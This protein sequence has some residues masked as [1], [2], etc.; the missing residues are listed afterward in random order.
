MTLLGTGRAAPPARPLGP[1]ASPR[2]P[3]DGGPP[4]SRPRRRTWRRGALVLL[5]V[6]LLVPAVSYGRALA[7]PGGGDWQV[8]SVEWI[9]DHGGT[10][11]VNWVENW[12][13]AHH[14]P[15]GAAP[16][17]S[18]LPRPVAGAGTPPGIYEPPA[19]PT[20]AGHPA[21]PGEGVWVP[22][23]TDPQGRPADYTTFLRPDP[24]HPSVVVGAAWVRA[25]DT[26]AHLAAGLR[27]PG[28][29]G[30]PDAGRV[31][32]TDVPA[33]VATFNS[34]W[35][36]KDIHGGFY[37]DGRTGPTLVD[38]QA[39]AVVD[40][41]GHLTVGQWGR[42]VWM[43]PHVRA[44]RQNLALV[45]D[46]GRPVPGLTVD[47]RGRW[48]SSKNQLQYTWRSGLG[49]DARGNLIYVAGSGLRL[50]TLARAMVDAGIQ[51]G[52]ELDIHT[53]MASFSSWQPAAGG[54]VAPTKL[55]PTM[56]RPADRYLSPDQRDFFYV[57]LRPAL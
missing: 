15:T 12:W 55:L 1:G 34:G 13:Y 36:F 37:L 3:A 21:V 46:R 56:H 26:V 40:D 35:K 38:G 51:R 23:R 42:D 27:Q 32:G 9:R 7:A 43:I 2:E 8:R 47:A 44:V 4:G 22:G 30:W 28:G 11:L 6:L 16:D 48:G 18:V 33:L 41:Q 5:T 50:Q 24:A 20:L 45:V 19:V 10:G 25:S 14:P 57:T 29:T 53:H 31:P 17:P 52:M 54:E 49:I 39:A